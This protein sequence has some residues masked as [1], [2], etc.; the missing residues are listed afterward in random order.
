M[1]P[2][3]FEA[4]YAA[5]PDPWQ[6][7]SSWYERRKL[8]VLLASLPRERYLTGWEPGCGIGVATAA[9]SDRVDALVASDGSETALRRARARTS[10]RPSVDI[11]AS[12]L[13]D[14]PLD[15]V[16][17]LVVAAEFLYYLEDLPA[18]LQALWSACAPGGHL[19]VVH[20]AHHPHDAYRS[21]P[22]THEALL[23]DAR[24]RQAAHLVHHRD[25]DFL[26]D[27]LEAPR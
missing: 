18:A 20:W 19:L 13:P 9:L 11:V 15:G 8:S 24:R 7:E 2:P 1:Q 6:V 23:S 22:E 3:D 10:D 21:G 27:V 5:E 4:T 17:E 25:E 16:V 26:L 14:V 12:S